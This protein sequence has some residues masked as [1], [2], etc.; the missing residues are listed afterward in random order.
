MARHRLMNCEFINSGSFKVNV[1]NKG[2]L[3]YFMM[4]MSADD[5]GF[6]DTTQ[7]IINSLEK[8]ENDNENIVNLTL[9]QND[10]KSA[11][12]DLI[13]KGYLYEFVDN[14]SNKVHLIRHFFF[15]NR[16]VKGLWTNYRKF[17]SQVDI[18]ENEYIKKPLKENNI[19]QNNINQYNLI[20]S[21]KEETEKKHK[22]LKYLSLDDF[23]KEKGVNHYEELST[24]DLK[25]WGEYVDSLDEND[26][27]T[28]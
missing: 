6:V 17:L 22:K 8:N 10:Y 26:I 1:S 15:H 14:H 13:D 9:L 20:Q 3:L 7:E 24:E 19:N 12:I 4:M 18:V 5:K 11:L 25:E 2:K 21:N 23:L 27:D 16:L 28:L